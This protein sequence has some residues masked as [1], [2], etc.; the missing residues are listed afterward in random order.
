LSADGLRCTG[1]KIAPRMSVIRRLTNR[2]DSLTLGFLAPVVV[3]VDTEACVP[4]QCV[5][6]LPLL[7]TERRDTSRPSTTTALASVTQSL[8]ATR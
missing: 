8:D 7:S 1:S 2:L 5:A 4:Q 3:P 6:I